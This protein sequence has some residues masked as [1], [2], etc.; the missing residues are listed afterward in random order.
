MKHVHLLTINVLG[1]LALISSACVAAPPNVVIILADDLGYSDVGCYGGEIDTPQLDA[2]AKNGVRFTQFYNTAR[3]WPTRGALLTG[4]YAQQIH[5]DA[6]PAVNGGGQGVRQSWARLLPEFL[7]PAGYRSFHSG[8]W[9]V[10]G[11]CST[12]ALIARWTCETKATFLQ[13]KAIRSMTCQSHRLRMKRILR[14]D[15]HRRSRD[16]VPEG[17]RGQSCGQAVLSLHTVHRTS[18]SAACLARRYC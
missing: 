8:K 15:C 9:H 16:R 5:R 11:K 2:L 3:C 18:F 10:D 6:L 13:P 14:H 12:V 17:S 4:F 1:F 7:K